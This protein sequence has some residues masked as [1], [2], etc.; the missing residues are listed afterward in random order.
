MF[1]IAGA[2]GFGRETYD[3]ILADLEAPEPI[4]I[5]DPDVWFLDENLAGE[6]VR[7]LRVIAPVKALPG[8]PFT[9]GIANSEV[10]RRL[11]QDLKGQGLDAAEVRHPAAVIGPD[12][13]VGVGCI[14]LANCH[15]SSSVKVGDFVQVNY[16]A[17]VGHDTVLE[18]YVTILP[19]ANISGSV[20][21]EEGV[22]VGSGA[23]VI[24][25]LRVGAGS[26]IGAGSVVTRDVPANSVVKGVPGRW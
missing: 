12:T 3:A 9:V 11:A 7:G 23:V 21:L 8:N 4:G 1:Y 13:T 26:F 18:D 10:R 22:T 14:F 17:T 20:T 24:Q 2:G 15:I 25:G 6:M 19:G 5:P 16:N